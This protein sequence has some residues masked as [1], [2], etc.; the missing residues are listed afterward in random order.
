MPICH[1]DHSTRQTLDES[2]NA[3]RF[4]LSGYAMDDNANLY[5]VS[6]EGNG[7]WFLDECD[8]KFMF[9]DIQ[10]RTH[11]NPVAPIFEG[12]MKS[13]LEFLRNT[14]NH[15]VKF[16][17][18]D[19]DVDTEIMRDLSKVTIPVVYYPLALRVHG[20]DSLSYIESRHN[21]DE[22]ILQLLVEINTE[23][24]QTTI[25]ICNREGK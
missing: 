3:Y 8:S 17:H 1:Y 5:S 2:G 16:H 11:F 24:K 21:T 6:P 9:D 4:P 18:S 23:T 22:Y 25:Y 19:F 15:L 7:V 12:N 10:K 14:V 13:A 20:T